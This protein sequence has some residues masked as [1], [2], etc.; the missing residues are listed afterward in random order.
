M[1][2]KEHELLRLLLQRADEQGR[3]KITQKELASELG[4][5]RN[6]VSEI[7]SRLTQEVDI[8]CRRTGRA[9]VYL[10]PSD[11]LSRNGKQRMSTTPISEGNRGERG[12]EYPDVNSRHQ[13]SMLSNSPVSRKLSS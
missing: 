10:L 6:R 8:R 5:S 12:E 1:F 3:V 13:M 7:L 9:N 11:L 2:G 4:L